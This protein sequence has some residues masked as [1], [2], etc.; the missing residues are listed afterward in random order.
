VNGVRIQR[1]RYGAICTVCGRLWQRGLKGASNYLLAQTPTGVRRATDESRPAGAAAGASEKPAA[2]HT[3]PADSSLRSMRCLCVLFRVRKQMQ[4]LLL[5]ALLASLPPCKP[6]VPAAF[7]LG[8][9]AGGPGARARGADSGVRCVLRRPRVW[10]LCPERPSM[11]A[12]LQLLVRLAPAAGAS[13]GSAREDS[14]AAANELIRARLNQLQ[15]Q[16]AE[17]CL[18]VGSRALDDARALRLPL[19]AEDI[20]L[21]LYTVSR[22][23]NCSAAL[24]DRALAVLQQHGAAANTKTYNLLLSACKPRAPHARRQRGGGGEETADP[25][26]RT[27]AVLEMME[28]ARIRRDD[29]SYTLIFS[30]CSRAAR[31]NG[32]R[33][34]RL[35][36]QFWSEMCAGAN[37]EKSA[38]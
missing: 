35:V 18:S 17:V 10:P 38:L 6:S 7:L 34:L 4:T 22:A 30:A 21:V 5:A 9:A 15:G 2:P 1:A 20:N 25:L 16:D 11:W 24:L 14:A 12:A 26:E 23:S 19:D 31:R 32:A 28:L 33:G 13:S 3:I 8:P 29:F 37:S 27:L 36:K